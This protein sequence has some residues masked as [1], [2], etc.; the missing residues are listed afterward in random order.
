M[1]FVKFTI[2]TAAVLTCCAFNN[3]PAKA[4]MSPDEQRAY[5]YG[6]ASGAVSNVCMNF[7]FNEIDSRS[8]V[9]RIQSISRLEGMTP[10]VW[11]V[12]LRAQSG[13]GRVCGDSLDRFGLYQ[14]AE[15]NPAVRL[16]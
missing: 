4:Q 2:A 10:R 7:R 9:N 13:P 14:G 11:N 1:T 6:F 8:F 3:Y 15:Y 5:D 12:V 16:Y